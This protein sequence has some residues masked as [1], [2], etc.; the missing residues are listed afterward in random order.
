MISAK[1]F[2]PDATATIEPGTYVNEFTFEGA[3]KTDKRIKL[4]FSSPKYGLV[5]KML[6]QPSGNYPMPGETQQEAI[7][8]ER[9]ENLQNLVAVCFAVLPLEAFVN[10]QA[11]DYEEFTS[12]L[13]GALK[14]GIGKSV[15]LTFIADRKGNT[16][17]GRRDWIQ[18]A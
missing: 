3:I 14:Q 5:S 6:Y 2:L 12:L 4:L 18:S 16:I 9:N 7:E 17:L 10:I 8:R 11:E 15:T 1:H 13:C